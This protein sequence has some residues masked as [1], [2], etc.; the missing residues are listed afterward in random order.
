[1]RDEGLVFLAGE[2]ENHGHILAVLAP[3]PGFGDVRLVVKA[4]HEMMLVARGR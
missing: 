3:R 2:V 4:Q 1:M